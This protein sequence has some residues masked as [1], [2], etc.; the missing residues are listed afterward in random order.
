LA[1]DEAQADP[2]THVDN[3]YSRAGIQDPKIVITTS[4][5]PSSKLLQ[6]SK[7][8]RLVFPNSHRIN[9]GNYVVKELAD[10]CRAN[11]ITDL[12]VV[13]E[14]R[15]V[16]DAMIV[17]HFPHGPTVYFTLN[18][19][20]LRHDIGTY[21]SSTVSE[22]YPHLIFDNFTS[23]L[24]G[25]VRDVLKHL[26]PVP[27]EDSKRVMTFSNEEDFIS[28]RHHV[29]VKIP[30]QVQLAEVGPRFE[31]KPYEIRQGTIEQ[32]EAERE[33]VL[34]HYTNTSKKRSLLSGSG[35]YGKPAASKTSS[36]SRPAKKAKR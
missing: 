28:F 18:N 6:F 23:Q 22:Q 29:F 3:E 21:K 7:E 17:S 2:T 11:D 12:V 30:K 32:T 34:A 4:R 15:G 19:V 10:A 27:K 8:M 9:R 5:D 25:R 13:H 31:M 20:S 26:F 36:T 14:H 35:T 16:P 24:G 1:F 33:W